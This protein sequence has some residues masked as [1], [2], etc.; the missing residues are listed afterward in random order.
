MCGLVSILVILK[1]CN[2]VILQ[3]YGMQLLWNITE[4]HAGG[5]KK[6]IFIGITPRIQACETWRKVPQFLTS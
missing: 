4:D 2:P 3:L 6:S 5:K 1:G